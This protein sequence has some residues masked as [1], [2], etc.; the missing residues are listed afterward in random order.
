MQRGSPGAKQ[1]ETQR[2]VADKMSEFSDVVMPNLEPDQIQTEKEVKQRIEK[3]A[4]VLRRK[5]VGGLDR[6]QR[7][8]QNRGNPGLE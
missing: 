8:P 7:H 6:D 2:K 3:S 1:K 4:G 5:P